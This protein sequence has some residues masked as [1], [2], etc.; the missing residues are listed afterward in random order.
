MAN[1][2]L[3]AA[4][5][6]VAP[7]ADTVNNAGGHA[8]KLSDKGAL[9][10]MAVTG[11]FNDTFYVTAD[12]QLEQAKAL[13]S[14]VDAA[15]IAKLAV[16]A[17]EKAFMKDLPAFLVAALA[18][19]D[20]GL[21]SKVFGRVIDNGKMLRNF[22]Q[23]VRSGQLGRKSLGTRPKKLVGSWLNAA[24]D[25]QLLAASVGTSPSLGDVIKLSHPKG[26][27]ATREAFYGYINGKKVEMGALPQVV[28]ELDAFRKGESTAVPK[29]PF[30]LLTSLP[31]STA[32]WTTVARNASWQQTRMNLNTF[33]RHG[34]FENR[35]MISLVA[36]RL[37]NPELVAKAKVFPYQ[38]LAAYLN[39]DSAVP[40]Q[41]ANAL[42]DAMELAVTNVPEFG[43]ETAVLVDT[44]GSMKN[45]VTG[46]RPGATSKIRCVDVASLFASAVLRRNP[47]ANVVPFD[48]RVHQAN[49]NG[50]DSIMTNTEKLA[51]FGGGG[52][53]LA[54]A[55]EHL[56][57]TGSRAELVIFVSDNESWHR[58]RGW[59]RSTGV[60]EQWKQYKRRVRNAKMVCIDIT[61]NTTTQASDAHDIL[62][63]GGFSDQVF[64]VVNQFANGEMGSA[65]WVGEIE[66]V[67]L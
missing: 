65:H 14:K 49:L 44:S 45:P 23:I 35:E 52:T 43:V 42:Q 46:N 38:L 6:A 57:K 58:D 9:A 62:N 66:K 31:L 11:V 17:R 26:A 55:L 5:R 20:V 4:S 16:Y 19:R 24:N 51:R 10:Q 41:I 39:I 63:V 8:Y 34:V 2:Q 36:E 40:K 67:Q 32:D 21:M 1:Q 61:P 22:V 54:C 28:R 60:M 37:R 47:E 29:V 30:E 50:R 56:N 27:D 15:F 3:F 59:N 18:V 33:L 53:D 64:T 25:A 13:V 48:T 12:A 7:V